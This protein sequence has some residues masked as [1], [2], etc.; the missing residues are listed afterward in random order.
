VAL[1]RSRGT[2][3]ATDPHAPIGTTF[4]FTLNAPARVSFAFTR[5]TPGRRV[6]GACVTATA[7]D[8]TR[9]RCVRT[10]TQGSLKFAAMPGR[11]EHRFTGVVPLTR[12]LRTGTY[13]VTM[14]A[15][16]TAGDTK[17]PAT[18]RFAIVH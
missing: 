15:T 9:P 7:L 10:T 12:A 11:N 18:L 4:S 3:D 5:R 16:N 13:S 8:Q 1:L 2:I 6:N 17:K 14:T